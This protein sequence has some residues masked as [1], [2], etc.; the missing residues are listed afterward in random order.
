MKYSGYLDTIMVLKLW[1]LAPDSIWPIPHG[2][3]I[4]TSELLSILKNDLFTGPLLL[5]ATFKMAAL[6]RSKCIVCR[7]PP[8]RSLY[9]DPACNWRL[10]RGYCI[11]TG[12]ICPRDLPEHV[13]W[14]GKVVRFF[15]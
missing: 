10:A 8:A 12:L 4:G 2:S 3:Y 5:F 7:L 11:T 15:Y 9:I 14:P 13:E 1:K 6:R